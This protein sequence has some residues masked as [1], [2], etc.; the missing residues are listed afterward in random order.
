MSEMNPVESLVKTWANTQQEMLIGWFDLVQGKEQLSRKRVWDETVRVWQSAV[1]ETLETQ[2][3]WL[4]DWPGRLQITSGSPTELRKNVQQ[5]YML[6]LGWTEAQQQLWQSW[7]R[8]VQHFGPLL[9]TG[10]QSDE[11]LLHIIRESGRAIID[12]Q[13]LWVQRWMTDVID[14]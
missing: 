11:Q 1:Q 10:S 4:R 2:A 6:L 13:T 9:D 3:K 8:L 14:R 7:F 5:A 12:A